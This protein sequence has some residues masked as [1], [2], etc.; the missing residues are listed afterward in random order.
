MNQTKDFSIFQS[1]V[2]WID[3]LKGLD[4]DLWTEPIAEGKWSIGEIV[5]HIKGWDDYLLNVTLPIV[6]KGEEITFPA[7]DPFNEKASK[8]AKSGITKNELINVVIQTRER[9]VQQLVEFPEEK[10]YSPIKVDGMSH[11]PHSGEPYSLGYIISDFVYHD[12]HHKQ[13]ITDFLV[14]KGV[15]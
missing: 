1:F 9:L 14:S 4:D 7:F 6:I 3:S 5:S 8:Y 11:C 13:Q 15:Y 10:L 2:Q 12:H